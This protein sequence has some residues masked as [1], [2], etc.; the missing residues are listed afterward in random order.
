MRCVY[1]IGLSV[2]LRGGHISVRHI[3]KNK[4]Y[5]LIIS[6]NIYS[7]KS[8]KERIRR[9]KYFAAAL[10]V[11]RKSKNHPISEENRHKKGEMLHRFVG[12]TKERELFYVQIKE[13]K[14]SSRKYF[15]SCFPID[16]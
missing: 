2:R 9:L 6:G 10:D 13:E 15:M 7:K 5:F 4:R 14:R 12:L 11:I 1:L 3:S 16:S 8:P